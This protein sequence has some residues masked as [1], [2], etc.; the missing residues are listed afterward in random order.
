MGQVILTS[1]TRDIGMP[2]AELFTFLSDLNN[3]EAM[4][5]EQVI[6]WKSDGERCT[7]TIKGMATIGMRITDRAPN[8]T[9]SIASDGKVP[10]NFTMQCF[11]KAIDA[12]STQ[13]FIELDANLSPMLKMMAANPLQNLVNIMVEKLKER[14]G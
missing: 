7:F 3:F 11:L 6:D 10:F 8:D 14:L 1:E 9:I 2:Q 12:A 5:P 13:I 4:M